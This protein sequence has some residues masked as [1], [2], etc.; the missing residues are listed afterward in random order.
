MAYR[1]AEDESLVVFTVSPKTAVN[2]AQKN[3]RDRISLWTLQTL[4]TPDNGKA[5]PINITM[6]AAQQPDVLSM[7]HAPVGVGVDHHSIAA[8]D[9]RAAVSG[10]YFRCTGLFE[11]VD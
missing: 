3:D 1:I 9:G 5:E 11:L 10:Q 6:P 8:S 2:G 7:S 4:H